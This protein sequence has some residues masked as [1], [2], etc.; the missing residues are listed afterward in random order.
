MGQ[1][2]RSSGLKAVPETAAL[3]FIQRGLGAVDGQAEPGRLAAKA[4]EQG[5]FDQVG[6]G[7]G[8]IEPEDQAALQG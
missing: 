8:L 1:G 6:N 7:L 5:L 4:R 3:W 2:I